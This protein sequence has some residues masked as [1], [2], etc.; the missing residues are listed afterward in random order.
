MRSLSQ[1]DQ[2]EAKKRELFQPGAALFNQIA[3]LNYLFSANFPS[4]DQLL[5]GYL[6]LHCQQS[7]L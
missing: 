4:S 7:I 3:N 6:L 1:C 2:L 5:N